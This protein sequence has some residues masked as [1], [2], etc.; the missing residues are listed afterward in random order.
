MLKNNYKNILLK[1]NSDPI[2]C[3]TSY[4]KPLAI[5]GKGRLCVVLKCDNEWCK[6]K[7]DKYSGWIK[8]ENLWGNFN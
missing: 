7:T 1:K 8:K 2:T 3:L 4:S 6:I 5:L